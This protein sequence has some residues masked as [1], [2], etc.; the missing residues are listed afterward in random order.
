LTSAALVFAAPGLHSARTPSSAASTA[1]RRAAAL[2]CGY[3]SVLL[4]IGSSWHIVSAKIEESL[5]TIFY[6][7][8][9]FD[10]IVL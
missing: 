8:L 9:E 6:V 1:R 2:L 5:S 3:S 10:I 7:A 4:Q